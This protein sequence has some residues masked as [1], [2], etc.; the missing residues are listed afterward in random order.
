MAAQNAYRTSQS[1]VGLG[2]SFTD[3]Y[4][5]L[6]QD[7]FARQALWSGY[8]HTYRMYKLYVAQDNSEA[9]IIEYQETRS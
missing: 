7:D 3:M 6:S 9:F 1:V 8:S 5:S 4:T 2:S